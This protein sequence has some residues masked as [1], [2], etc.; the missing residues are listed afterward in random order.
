MVYRHPIILTDSWLRSPL[1]RSL[2]CTPIYIQSHFRKN[3]FRK[4]ATLVYILEEYMLSG[5]IPTELQQFV[6]III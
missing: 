4:T 6:D 2:L 1:H 3:L 5:L